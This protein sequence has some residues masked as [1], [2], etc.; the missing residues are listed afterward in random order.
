LVIFEIDRNYQTGEVDKELADRTDERIRDL[1]EKTLERAFI[2][3]ISKIHSMFG[4]IPTEALRKI[5]DFYVCYVQRVKI[6]DKLNLGLACAL[7]LV[8]GDVREKGEIRV[9]LPKSMRDE[10]NDSEIIG[11]IAHELGHLHDQFHYGLA[12]DQR[13]GD[14]TKMECEREADQ[15]AI[16]L[17]FEEE[18]KAMRARH[19]LNS[20]PYD[21]VI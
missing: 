21:T 11:V 17:G 12:V 15:T 8:G 3:E 6:V 5:F 7:M 19:P 4:D 1:A 14:K 16:D 10:F 2:N 13:T 9:F 20:D 18:I